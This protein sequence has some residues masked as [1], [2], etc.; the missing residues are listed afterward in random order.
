LQAA[1]RLQLGQ[2]EV[3][4]RRNLFNAAKRRAQR[5]QRT[6]WNNRL[7]GLL[8]GQPR[9]FWSAYRADGGG[10]GAA[11]HTLEEH[12]AHWQ[13]VLGP[14]ACGA[15]P[16]SGAAGPRELAGELE[17]GQGAAPGAAAGRTAAEALE[18]DFKDAEVRAAL[19]GMRPG[20][21]PGLDGLAPC[22]VKNAFEVVVD[23]DGSLR[24]VFLLDAHLAR[25]S[26][27][28]LRTRYPPDW[29][30][31][32]LTPFF[33]GKGSGADLHNY[34]PIQSQCCLAKLFSMLLNARLYAYSQRGA[35]CALSA[36]RASAPSAAPQ[37]TFSSCATSSTG[38]AS[39][40]PPLGRRG[41]SAVSLFALL[42]LR[43]RTIA[44]TGMR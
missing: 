4:R 23:P 7:M 1:S 36:R 33:K 2:A 31:Q 15:L 28:I 43:R 32:P 20:A 8:R 6:R 29:N 35:A 30:E 40:R 12:A 21:A 24:R 3:R 19:R 26:T 9:A 5:A 10:V 25:L 38:S 41:G 42:T 27:I 37:I 18:E 44:S 39:S 11:C 22:L 34:R 14:A 17:L 13:A 16:D